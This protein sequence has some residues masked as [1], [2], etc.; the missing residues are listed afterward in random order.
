MV[1]DCFGLNDC[2]NEVVPPPN[3]FMV[4]FLGLCPAIGGAGIFDCVVSEARR[5]KRLDG[6]LVGLDGV[7]G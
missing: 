1:E 6:A 4:T 2:P 5:I 7:S 3:L